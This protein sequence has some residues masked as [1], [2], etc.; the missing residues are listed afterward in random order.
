MSSNSTTSEACPSLSTLPDTE[1][2]LEIPFHEIF[3]LEGVKL[4]DIKPNKEVFCNN[5]N[6]IG[7]LI[8]PGCS[9]A[10]YCSEDCIQEDKGL[11]NLVCKK[12][13]KLKERPSRHHR[14]AILFPVD[15]D[16]PRFVWIATKG[17]LWAWRDITDQ[18]AIQGAR[19][20]WVTISSLKSL[21]RLLDD[22]HNIDIVFDR[23]CKIKGCPQNQA[24]N[25]LVEE[26]IAK[27]YGGS[28]VAIRTD[29]NEM[30]GLELGDLDTRSLRAMGDFFRYRELW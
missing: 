9:N 10:I 27:Y 22:C 5:C 1:S 19:P 20:G 2:E 24:L 21:G 12:F 23:D 18:H 3:D 7:A 13:G 6:A 8:C 25:A 11:H 4:D 28:L 15:E 30:G 14:R 26:P 17:G 16:G 29:E